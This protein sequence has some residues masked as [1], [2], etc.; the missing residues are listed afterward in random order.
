MNSSTGTKWNLHFFVKHFNNDESFPFHLAIMH[1]F[2]LVYHIKPR[3]NTLLLVV[4]FRLGRQNKNVH[5]LQNCRKPGDALNRQCIVTSLAA[6]WEGQIK[7]FAQQWRVNQR[8]EEAPH[9][10]HEDHLLQFSLFGWEV[11]LLRVKTQL[12]GSNSR[13]EKEEMHQIMS[14]W[15]R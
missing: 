3:Q 1:P 6:L 11:K 5:I 9:T 12:L 13:N 14:L 2:V 15:C 7:T 8:S 4:M 10:Q